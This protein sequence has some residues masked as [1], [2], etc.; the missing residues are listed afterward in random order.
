MIKQVL[1]GCRTYEEAAH[2]LGISLSTLTRRIRR[3]K[4]DGHN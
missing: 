1:A 3:V 2:H 4:N